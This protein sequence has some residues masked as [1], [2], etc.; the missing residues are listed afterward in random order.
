ML[1]EYKELFNSWFSEQTAEGSVVSTMWESTKA[2]VINS[3]NESV[4]FLSTNQNLIIAVV[5]GFVVGMLY[6]KN[7]K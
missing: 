6:S 3:F 4:N 1:E 5:I 7:K 2:L